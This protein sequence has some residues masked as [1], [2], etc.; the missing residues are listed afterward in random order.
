MIQTGA[1]KKRNQPV[2]SLQY[3]RFGEVA[4]EIAAAYVRFGEAASETAAESVRFGEAASETAAAEYVCFGEVANETAAAESVRFGEAASETAAGAV[5]SRKSGPE[6]IQQKI[7]E[8]TL[9]VKLP[10]KE[11]SR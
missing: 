11:D 2:Q 7:L 1:E 3:V 4:S 5:G 8:A 9:T 10:P 6:Q